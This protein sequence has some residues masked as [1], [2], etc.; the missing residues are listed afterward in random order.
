MLFLLISRGVLYVRVIHNLLQIC[1]HELGYRRDSSQ[2]LDRAGGS[3]RCGYCTWT[4][5][6]QGTLLTLQTSRGVVSLVPR[7]RGPTP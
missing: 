7:P 6:T 5:R 4:L 3:E 2:S 1:I